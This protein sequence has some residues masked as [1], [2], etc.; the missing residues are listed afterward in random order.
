MAL[1]TEKR[2]FYNQ[3]VVIDRAVRFMTTVTL[4]SIIGM[5][6][7][8]RALLFSMAPGACFFNCVFEKEFFVYGS[9]LIMT[10]SAKDPLFRYRMVAG[11]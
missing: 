4:F 11:Q 10:V 9:M 5:F 8:K 2:L 7:D 3:E 6:K 1:H